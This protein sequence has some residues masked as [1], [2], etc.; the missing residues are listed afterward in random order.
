MSGNE[1]KIKLLVDDTA[2][3]DLEKRMQGIFNIKGAGASSGASASANPIKNLLKLGAI[4][5]GVGALVATVTKIS[6]MTVNASPMLKAM[7]Q[8][9]NTSIT[10]ILRP[11][12]DF[13]GFILRPI[14]LY[15][16]RY[17]AIP[18]YKYFTPWMQKYGNS[19]GQ[20]LTAV[21]KTLTQPPSL[22]SNPAGFAADILFPSKG[23]TD[24]ANWL[25][26]LEPIKFPDF[27]E[28]FKKLNL[29]SITTSW[30]K[31][32]DFFTGLSTNPIKTVWD[33]LTTLFQGIGGGVKTLTSAWDKLWGW[34]NTIGGGIKTVGN[35]WDR[36]FELF[37]GIGAGFKTLSGAWV[38]LWG[39]FSEVGSDIT[40]VFTKAW[41][42]LT[43][44]WK[45][46][47]DFFK[48][49]LG[50]L[51]KAF[52]V[53]APNNGGSSVNNITNGGQQ[54]V[55][56]VINIEKAIGSDI[57]SIMKDLKDPI[58]KLIQQSQSRNR[59]K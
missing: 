58:T 13:I 27:G 52:N 20:G 51:L 9:F 43:D 6:Q 17:I 56:L 14:M 25:K 2:I 41:N 36:F 47:Q 40:N 11:I 59:V 54:A 7:L 38:K 50:T 19:I 57:D 35:A 39:F 26:T 24:L 29:D 32:I 44:F 37:Q 45:Q 15:F 10:L 31:I 46:V 1:Y 55:N 12:G 53:P 22:Q 48:D 49:P 30:G 34:F 33:Q 18:F 21:L 5:T 8:L 42:A 23:A 16:L 3:K 28:I 4:A